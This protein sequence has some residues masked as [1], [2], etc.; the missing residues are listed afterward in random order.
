MSVFDWQAIPKGS[1]EMTGAE[2]PKTEVES[3]FVSTV[4]TFCEKYMR[5]IGIKLD[6]MSPDEVM[7][8]GSPYWEFREKF[9]ELEI[10]PSAFGDFSAEERARLIPMIFEE[11]GWADAGLSIT[12]GACQ[13]PHG[14]AIEFG[15]FHL[16]EK[17]KWDLIGSWAITE[18]DHGSDSLDGNG[19]IFHP[20]GDY[21]RPNCMAKMDGDHLVI[22][23]QKSAWVSNGPIADICVLYCLSSDDN[24]VDT[25]KGYVV[26]VPLDAAGVSRG[27]SIDKLGQRALPQGELYFDN[28]RVEKENI[29]AG[30]EDYLRA[31]YAVHTEANTQMGSVFVGTARSAY[32]L[33][34]AYAHE[35]KQGGVPIIKHQLVAHKL[36]HMARKVEAA[37]A[38][39]RRVALY[40]ASAPVP[41]LHAAMMTKITS[42]QTAFEVANDALQ[43]FGGNGNTRE[44]LVEKILRDARA[45][46]IEDGCNDVLAL[47]G[48]AYL[49]NE[50]LL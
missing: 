6:K 36:F 22:N 49:F 14:L 30:P 24:N 39:N 12:I 28:V 38:L 41:A 9:L 8:E 31:M 32:E 18:P 20:K 21:G 11:F 13:L 37:R 25:K 4:H 16:L 29:I 34:L 40:H 42:T 23:G 44:Y 17:Y 7:A 47:K 10:T 26:I 5:P 19:Q 43:I 15:K 2:P 3:E 27:K 50:E 33:A 45:S 35:R 1:L 46:L 48:G